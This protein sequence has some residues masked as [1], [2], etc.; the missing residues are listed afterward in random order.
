MLCA[1]SATSRNVIL[2]GCEEI[3]LSLLLSDF[4]NEEKL[5]SKD[6]KVTKTSTK[7]SPIQGS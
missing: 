1:N 3:S 2:A 7:C 6:L 5:P 4:F